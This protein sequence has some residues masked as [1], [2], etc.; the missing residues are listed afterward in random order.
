MLIVYQLYMEQLGRCWQYIGTYVHLKLAKTVCC[1]TVFY[2][3]FSQPKV[4]S[5]WQEMVKILIS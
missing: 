3:D 5:T 1:I 4:T 2:L